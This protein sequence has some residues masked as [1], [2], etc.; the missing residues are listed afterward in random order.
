MHVIIVPGFWL[1]ADAWDAVVPVLREAG[2]SVEAVT[3]DGDT[4]D[5]QVAALVERLDDVAT[6]EEPVVLVGHSGG[7]PRRVHGRRPRPSLVQHLVYVDTFPRPRGRLRE[8]RTAGRGRRRAA[9][10]WDF[11]EPATVRGMTTELRTAFEHR[12]VPEPASVPSDP[13]HYEAP[14]ARRPGD[15]HHVR[16]LADRPGGHGRGPPDL[17]G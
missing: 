12:A 13:F 3:R 14:P 11:W 2:H 7:R 6:P 4:L 15:R 5:E 9:A 8:R 17:G 10:A 1:E 16:D